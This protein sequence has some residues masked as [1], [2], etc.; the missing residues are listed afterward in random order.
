MKNSGIKAAL[1]GLMLALAGTAWAAEKSGGSA[2]RA[3]QPLGPGDQ[4]PRAIKRETPKYPYEMRQAGLTGRVLVDFIVDQEGNVRNPVVIQSNNPWF[5]RTAIRTISRWKFV[6]GQKGGRAVNVRA[7]QLIEFDQTAPRTGA[8]GLWQVSKNA[9]HN[10]LAPELRWDKAPE[11]VHTTFPVFPFETLKAGTSGKT[12]LGFLIGPNGRVV[13]AKLQ[14]ATTPEMGLATLAMIDTWE[15]TPPAKKDG[16]P[17]YAAVAIEHEFRARDGGDAPVTDE[18]REILR[19]LEKSP[20]KIEAL[21]GLDHTP[22]PVSRRLP[23]Y[24][25]ALLPTRQ[26]GEA[27]IEFYIDKDGDAQLPRVIS[28]TAPEFGYAA[29][30]A[31]ATWRYEVPQKQGKPVVARVQIPIGF[32]VPAAAPVASPALPPE[33]T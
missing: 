10:Q 30:Q 17:C 6:P 24:P 15:F 12:R 26:N 20:E 14:E 23:V 18:A 22:K 27:V 8:K 19:L 29:V 11:P 33:G 28:S 31:V 9:R 7:R 13:S 32:V 2:G 4:L 21:A 25:S 16:T 1:A 5:E 3:L